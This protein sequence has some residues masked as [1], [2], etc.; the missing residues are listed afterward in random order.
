MSKPCKNSPICRNR[1]EARRCYCDPCKQI[2]KDIDA[3]LRP[4]S[5]ARVPR[6]RAVVEAPHR[7]LRKIGG[8][9]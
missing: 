6:P 5:R 9:R 4:P 2:L 1:V 3:A 8:I 7:V